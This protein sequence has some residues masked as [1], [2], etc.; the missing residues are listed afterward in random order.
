MIK[1]VARAFRCKRSFGSGEFVT[2]AEL[3]ERER[4]ASSYMTRIL[5]LTLLA[6][7]IVYAILDGK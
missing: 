3:A 5:R 1:A 4:I 7:A 2:I 6:P